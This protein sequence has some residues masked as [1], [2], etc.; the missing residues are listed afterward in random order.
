VKKDLIKTKILEAESMLSVAEE[1]LSK[2]MSA[3]QAG[4]R[5]DKTIVSESIQDAFVKLREARSNVAKL[6][7]LLNDDD[8]EL[9]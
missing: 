5:A 6:V 1:D 8:E 3:L 2:A 4:A 7:I 9:A